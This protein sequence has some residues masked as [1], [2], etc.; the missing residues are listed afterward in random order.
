MMS[1]SYQPL[2]TV[3]L[4]LLLPAGASA[5]EKDIASDLSDIKGK[6][7][8]LFDRVRH[9][10]PHSQAHV[11]P[12][13]GTNLVTLIGGVGSNIGTAETAV[14]T[15]ITTAETAVKTKIGT[16]ETNVKNKIGDVESRVSDVED[17]LKGITPGTVLAK[18]Q[19]Q[20][21][22]LS[23]P[24]ISDGVELLEE[25]L[26]DILGSMASRLACISHTK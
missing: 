8:D 14:K 9:N 7:I 1:R 24:P 18:L 16:V 6:V 15:A 10:L 21:D 2:A 4:L 26:R 17:N 11:P 25:G 12:G 20:L 5:Q 13:N 23:Q 22:K 19:D 3:F